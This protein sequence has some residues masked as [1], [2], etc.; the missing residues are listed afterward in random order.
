MNGSG[1]WHAAPALPPEHPPLA[2]YVHLPWCRRKCPYCDFNS[3]AV[4]GDLP[5]QA[6]VDALL[7]DLEL[8]LPAVAGRPVGSVY[9]GGGTPS[10]FSAAALT[11]LLAGLRAR[12][13]LADGAEVTVEVNPGTLREGYFDA[14]REAGVNRVSVGVQSFDDTHLG[15]LGRIHDAAAA[16]D[17]VAA[18]QAAGLAEVNVDLMVGLPGQSLAQALADVDAA[19]ALAPTHI[20]HYQLTIEPG[21]AFAKRPPAVPPEAH[22][23]AA[24]AACHERLAAAG[25]EHYEV[26]ALAR[27]GHV[28]R[29]NV[30]YWRFGDYLGIGAGAHAKL[31]GPGG[32]RR[33]SRIA[34]PQRY[35]AAA[36]SEAA[37]ASTLTLDA[38]D[39]AVEF[40]LNALRLREGFDTTLFEQRTGVSW[41]TQHVAEAH[42]VDAG[43][44]AS[45][46]SRRH[47][48]ARGWALLDTLLALFL[49]AR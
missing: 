36:G 33:R 40:L 45:D 35:M 37:V 13:D 8:D 25:F 2:L 42:A 49:P 26:S 43:L 46:G 29:H 47:A 18:A 3:H 5:E 34:N 14:L 28:S 6:Y 31:S 41:A 20:S 39:A 44:L 12:L 23:T 24:Q 19:L 48:S 15:V 4:D 21:T 17:T 30:N 10:L 22:I 7:A 32:I 38:G 27:P 1:P 16:R 9:L 11:R